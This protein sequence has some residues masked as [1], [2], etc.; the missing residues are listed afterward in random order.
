ME[1]RFSKWCQSEP[2]IVQSY[3]IKWDSHIEFAACCCGLNF[4]A[5][6]LQHRSFEPSHP[7]L[8]MGYPKK[9][10]DVKSLDSSSFQSEK[11]PKFSL[12]NGR[13]LR[14]FFGEKKNV[15][16]VYSQIWCHRPSTYLIWTDIPQE[17]RGTPEVDL[18]STIWHPAPSKVSIF[19]KLSNILGHSEALFLQ[20]DCFGQ[21]VNL[22]LSCHHTYAKIGQIEILWNTFCA[23]CYASD[24]Y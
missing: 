5:T 21:S 20:N 6:G 1:V 3:G 22:C 23:L 13:F 15:G 17:F 16:L 2:I 19:Q 10:P 9:W 14:C 11:R 12:Q 18:L 7:K 4:D 8:S 24:F